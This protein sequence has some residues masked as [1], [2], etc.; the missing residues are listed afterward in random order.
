MEVSEEHK[1]FS[2][3]TNLFQANSD[4]AAQRRAMSLGPGTVFN[5]GIEDELESP[6]E[7]R[8]RRRSAFFIQ[9]DQPQEHFS[10]LQELDDSPTPSRN[11]STA[12]GGSRDVDTGEVGRPTSTH[13]PRLSRNPSADD[14]PLYRDVPVSPGPHPER[15][16]LSPSH[17]S[18]YLDYLATVHE[19]PALALQESRDNLRAGLDNSRRSGY[20]FN[21]L[22]DCTSIHKTF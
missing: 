20:C 17:S 6:D 3:K 8:G 21:C 19:N 12:R 10:Y 18:R 2:A 7:R 4:A 11:A 5:A 13:S 22:T 1:V 16:N 15:P 9:P 14:P